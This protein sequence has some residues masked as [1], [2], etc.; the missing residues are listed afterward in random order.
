MVGRALT[1]VNAVLY[2]LL[3]DEVERREAKQ[4]DIRLRRTTFEHAKTLEDF[5]S[6]F[7]PTIP[8]AK[9][10]D[11][12][13]CAYVARKEILCLVGQSGVGKSHLAQAQASRGDGRGDPAAPGARSAPA[14]PP[15]GAG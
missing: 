10:F 2:R 1:I 13:P 15:P 6:T 5:D 9:I 11:L 8:K 4:L 12:A 7:N 14:A 3:T